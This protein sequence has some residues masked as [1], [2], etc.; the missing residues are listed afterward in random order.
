MPTA[1][2]RPMPSASALT[3]VF[4]NAWINCFLVIGLASGGRIR[5]TRRYPG[6]HSFRQPIPVVSA[7]TPE[8]RD[9]VV[10]AVPAVPIE[11]GLVPTPVHILAPLAV[12][13]LVVRRRLERVGL[14]L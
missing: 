6:E 10:V 3:V 12:V 2:S 1:S 9:G 8:R 14:G 7:R 11:A 4:I 5:S 13:G